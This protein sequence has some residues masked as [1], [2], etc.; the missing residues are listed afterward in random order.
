M[1]TSFGIKEDA[2]NKCIYLNTSESKFII[3][4]LYVD[5]IFL[6]RSSVELLT[7]TKFVLNS[8]F[9]MNLGDAFVVLG[10]QFFVIGHV[11]FL[12]C[13]REDT[14]IKSLRFNKHSLLPCIQKVR[15]SLNLN[16]L[17]MT[18][19]DRVKMKKFHMLLILVV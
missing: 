4:A 2:S 12:D 1:V 13:L 8:H 3:L 7:G 18:Y 19:N 10:I 16:V 9:G 15:N 17:K 5:D 6:V 11:A 14:L